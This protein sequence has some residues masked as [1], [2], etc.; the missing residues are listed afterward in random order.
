MGQQFCS[1]CS[2]HEKNLEKDLSEVPNPNENLGGVVRAKANL[3]NNS[4]TNNNFNASSFQSF[5]NTTNLN[6]E[7]SEDSNTKRVEIIEYEDGSIFTGEVKNQKKNGYGVLQ[8]NKQ[9][10][11]GEFEN[12]LFNGFG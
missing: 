10:F 1:S 6:N 5:S 11:E 3:S 4:T 9:F 8:N 12:D 7:N 2:N